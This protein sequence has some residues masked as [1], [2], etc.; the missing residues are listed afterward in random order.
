MVGEPETSSYAR[1]SAHDKKM[2]HRRDRRENWKTGSARCPDRCGNPNGGGGRESLDRVATNKDE[3]SADESDTGDD[4][5]SDSRGI[6]NDRTFD[7]DIRKAVLTH[8]H[9]QG[10]AYAD[11][12]MSAE[13]GTLLT[14]I[15]LEAD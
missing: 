14:E 6:E 10:S 12:G 11:E 5:G 3:T 1:I 8:Q 2:P 13:A 9:K 4:L 7:K 15:A